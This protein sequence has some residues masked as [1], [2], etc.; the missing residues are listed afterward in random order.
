MEKLPL[1]VL[2]GLLGTG[3]PAVGL[4]ESGIVL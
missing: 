3:R 2:G 4:T 1:R